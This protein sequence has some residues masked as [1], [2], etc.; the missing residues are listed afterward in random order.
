[1]KNSDMMIDFVNFNTS[2][3]PFLTVDYE[4]RFEIFFNS[5]IFFAILNCTALLVLLII[6]C[7]VMCLWFSMLLC[8]QDSAGIL[9]DIQDNTDEVKREQNDQDSVRKNSRTNTNK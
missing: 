7:F 8:C 3:N 1:M 9:G 4:Q 2:S 5:F 6:S